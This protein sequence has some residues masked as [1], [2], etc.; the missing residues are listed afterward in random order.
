VS[1]FFSQ[2][3]SAPF[4]ISI[5]NNLFGGYTG[6]YLNHWGQSLGAFN[7][8][9]NYFNTSG[10]G[11]TENDYEDPPIYGGWIGS[12]GDDNGYAS[13]PAFGT[14]PTVSPAFQTGA[15]GRY[16]YGSGM[17]SLFDAGSAPAYSLGYYNYTTQ[18]NQSKETSSAIDIGFHYVAV[19]GNGVPIDTD[20]DGLW[21]YYED[22]N[23]DG[24]PTGD[25]T[26]FIAPNSYLYS[27]TGSTPID[28]FTPIR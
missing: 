20:R 1:V 12:E 8:H 26:S 14:G 28:V 21:D 6:F 10:I 27:L 4:G 13:W 15:L 16:Y 22:S 11:V 25:A 9:D 5:R 19:D 18:T 2:G 23:G 17:S 24:D 3:E 7:V